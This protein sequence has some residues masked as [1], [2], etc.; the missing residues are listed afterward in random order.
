MSDTTE[1]GSRSQTTSAAIDFLTHLSTLLLLTG[2]VAYF[3]G[4]IVVNSYLSKYAIVPY[5]FTQTKYVSAGLLYLLMTLGFTSIIWWAYRSMHRSEA[6]RGVVWDRTAWA[7]WSV[8]TVPNYALRWIWPVSPNRPEWQENLSIVLTVVAALIAFW[9]H[10]Y[11]SRITW[12]RGYM[13][14]G[15]L[16]LIM[17]AL[18]IVVTSL[19]IGFTTFEFYP[20]FLAAVYYVYQLTT[21]IKKLSTVIEG[22]IFGTGFLITSVYLFGL[23]Y[24]PNVPAYYGGGKPVLMSIVLNPENR[25]P[26][27]KALDRED[28]NCVMQNIAVIHENSENFYVLPYGIE[29]DYPAVALPKKEVLISIYQPKQL[30]ENYLCL[31]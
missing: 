15:L 28:W 14:K 19:R 23:Y 3:I 16:A 10:E 8:F 21:P 17:M 24:Y 2:V 25:E 22:P 4:F 11:L 12:L 7:I 27:G 30:Q 9:G 5:D 20:V 13:E 26:V 29:F 6:D 18:M 31:E 1:A